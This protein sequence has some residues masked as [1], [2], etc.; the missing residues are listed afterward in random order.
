MAK[1]YLPTTDDKSQSLVKRLM[2]ILFWKQIIDYY[3]YYYCGGPIHESA[4][5]IAL[6]I[7]HASW[8]WPVCHW[9][10]N[11]MEIFIRIGFACPFMVISGCVVGRPH[12]HTFSGKLWSVN[13]VMRGSLRTCIFIYLNFS[14]RT[15]SLFL[16]LG[17]CTFKSRNAVI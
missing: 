15:R 11:Y 10:V 2:L 9:I 4:Y 16:Y 14:L 12:I 3:D 5:L 6:I 1:N 13:G 7:C 8:P 17:L